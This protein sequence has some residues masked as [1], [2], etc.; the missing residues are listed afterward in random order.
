MTTIPD[1]FPA[2]QSILTVTARDADAGNNS[3]ISYE[4][5]NSTRPG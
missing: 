5:V 4:I 1:T 2:N 3:L